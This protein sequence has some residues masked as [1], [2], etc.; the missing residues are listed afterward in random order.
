MEKKLERLINEV[1]FH[2]H[3][4]GKNRA[5]QPPP[6]PFLCSCFLFFWA[7]ARARYDK[8]VSTSGMTELKTVVV[9]DTDVGK[10]SLAAR[11]VH[12]ILPQVAS[13][14]IGASFLQK[15]VVVGGCEEIV[16]QIWDTAGQERFRAMAPM[17]YRHARIAGH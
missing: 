2:T 1:P 7:A 14:T 3:R 15:R 17:Y 16:L 12:G 4:R 10:T 6:A 11:F 9:G 8:V 13:P 5:F